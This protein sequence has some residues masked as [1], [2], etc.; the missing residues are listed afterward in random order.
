MAWGIVTDDGSG[1]VEGHSFGRWIFVAQHNSI[2]A[3]AAPAAPPLILEGELSRSNLKHLNNLNFTD[4]IRALGFEDKKD[5]KDRRTAPKPM[6]T[7]Q[8]VPFE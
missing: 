4:C 2:N 3:P 1:L 7:T 6:I 5:I 8:R